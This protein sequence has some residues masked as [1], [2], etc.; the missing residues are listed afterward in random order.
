MQTDAVLKTLRELRHATNMT[1]YAVLHPT[2]PT[3]SVQAVHRITARL[4]ERGEIGLAP[5]DGRQLMLDANP[6]TH[7]HF[8]CTSCG[9]LMDIQLPESTIAAIQAQLGRNLVR[10][11]IV[12]NGRCESCAQAAE[13]EEMSGHMIRLE[14]LS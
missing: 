8:A 6:H 7:D 10:D 14:P 12:L 5:S 13:E 11:G 3:L 4:L 2:M 1:L 9:G